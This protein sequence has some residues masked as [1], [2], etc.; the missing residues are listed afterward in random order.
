MC[1]NIKSFKRVTYRL[2]KIV[3]ITTVKNDFKILALCNN[4]RTNRGSRKS[5]RE[6]GTA[7]IGKGI[8]CKGFLNLILYNAH[9]IQNRFS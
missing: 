6:A 8:G 2:T 7:L 3:P 5:L 9:T 1:V 4:D